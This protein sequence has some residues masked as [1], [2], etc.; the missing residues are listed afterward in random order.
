MSEGERKIGWFTRLGNGLTRLRLIL[1]NVLFFG[2]LIVMLMLLFGGPPVPQVPDGGALVLDPRGAIV[3]QRSP[4]D[5]IQQWLTPQAVLAE[6]ELND[7]LDALRHAAEDERI[8]MAVLDLDDL[9]FV[10][11]AHA[12]AIGEALAAFRAADKQVVAYGSYYDQ[13][14]YLIASFADAI[15]M[16]PLGQVMLPGFSLN[17][18]YFKG[19]LDKLDVNVHVFR[20]GRYKEFVEPYTRTGMS[21]EAREANQE[22]VDLLWR[23]LGS[24]IVE[25][26]QLDRA[27]FDRY[28]QSYADA[29]AETN[30]DFASLAVEYHLVDE[31][32]TPDQARARIVDAVGEG[33]QGGFNGIGFRAYLEAVNGAPE[34]GEDPRIAVI[35]GQGPIVMGDDLRGVIAAER[36]VQLIRRVRDDRRVAALVMRLNTPGGS[37]FASELIRQEL[38]LTQLAGKPV[39]VSMGPL[40]ASGGY[41]IASTADAIVAEPTTITGSIGVFGIVPTF[42]DSLASIG[43]TSDGVRTSPL[44]PVNPLAG[45]SEATARVLQ[46]GTEHAYRRFLNLV[47]RGRDL[48]LEQ[49]ERIAQGRVWLGLQA[50]ELGLVDEL[51]D[52]QA[53]IARA[54]ELAGLERWSLQRI[55]PPLTPREILLR[56]LFGSLGRVTGGTGSESGVSPGNGRLLPPLLRRLGE[57]WQALQSLDDP[58]HS[59]ALCLSCAVVP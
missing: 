27:R 32:L 56:E 41:W 14:P 51:G 17:Q 40:A 16:H 59:Y 24:Q 52:Q 50:V 49:V 55:E 53:A 57:T 44:G 28:T 2:F 8:R 18:M 13:Q 45:L 11:V 12:Q 30:G 9:R 1:S 22:L 48:S 35:T 37:A 3:E 34:P 6:T 26:R 29:V 7:L 54:A 42:E 23:E 58:R 46:T 33:D 21:E 39:V 36:I 5:P 10:S 19:L 31:L 43:V 20:V 4:V 47:A 25:N 38:E 15:Y